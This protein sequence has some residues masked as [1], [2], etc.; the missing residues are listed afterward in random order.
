MI[1]RR[2]G[3]WQKRLLIF[4]SVKLNRKSEGNKGYNEVKVA[5]VIDNH[6]TSSP[7]D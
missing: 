6:Q 1:I 5:L 2:V 3:K 7:A 4:I